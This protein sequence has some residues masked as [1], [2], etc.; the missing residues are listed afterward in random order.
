[1]IS[2]QRFSTKEH[3][4]VRY[5]AEQAFRAQRSVDVTGNALAQTYWLRFVAPHYTGYTDFVDSTQ[6]ML[7]Y[8]EVISCLATLEK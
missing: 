6:K 1:M 3:G 4:K 2:G 8:M 5:Y 7:K